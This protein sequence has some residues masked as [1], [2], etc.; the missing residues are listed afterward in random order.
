MEPGEEKK[1]P[2]PLSVSPIIPKIIKYPPPP[3]SLS[4][5]NS[6][7]PLSQT[8]SHP[9]VSPVSP[10]PSPTTPQQQNPYVVPLPTIPVAT[11]IVSPTQTTSHSTPSSSI[12]SLTPFPV[13][14]T[15][16][17]ISPISSFPS[18]SSAGQ[19]NIPKFSDISVEEDDEPDPP[20]RSPVV[21]PRN[22]ELPPLPNRNEITF[23]STNITNE[24]PVAPPPSVS[25]E[26]VKKKTRE[27]LRN[28]CLKEIYQT[29]KDYIDDLENIISVCFFFKLLF[30]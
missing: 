2:L 10:T 17:S 9:P 3:S 4:Q 8:P 12:P 22:L 13:P 21:S 5:N 30:F 7:S 1:E 29:E 18:M 23:L 25:G 24:N 27:D 15:S 20:P 28:D 6:S 14:S 26:P 16:P 19:R 11:P